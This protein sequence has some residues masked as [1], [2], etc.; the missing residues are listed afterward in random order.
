[1]T[2]I[3]NFRIIGI[4]QGVAEILDT[5]DTISGAEF[6]KEQYQSAFGKE[7]EILIHAS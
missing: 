2:S 7:W 4:Y 3:D 5:A 6:L 1:M